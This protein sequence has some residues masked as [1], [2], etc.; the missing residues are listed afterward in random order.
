MVHACHVSVPN[1]SQ[2]DWHKLQAHLGLH[3]EDLSQKTPNP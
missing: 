2:K 1:Q 3:S